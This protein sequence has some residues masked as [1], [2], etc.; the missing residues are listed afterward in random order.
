MQKKITTFLTFDGRA[1]EAVEFY[2]SVFDDSTILSTTRYEAG[3]PGL[4]GELM[5]AT[6]ELAGQEF[7]ALNGGPSFTFSQ[8]ISLFVDCED[9]EEVD[10]LW[11]R[12]TDGGEP[13]PCGWLTDRFG[14]SWQ[15]IPRVLG[16]LLADEDR[17]KAGRVMQAMLQMSKIEI[18]G[19]RRAHEGAEASSTRVT[20]ARGAL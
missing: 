5:S 14:V 10:E 20:G 13:G 11:A 7:M 6:F 1:E 12:L 4:E 9:Q 3:G 17:E 16:E 19:L 18:A 8:G 15:I 2:T